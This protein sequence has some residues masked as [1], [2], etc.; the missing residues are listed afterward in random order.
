MLVREKYKYE[1][2]AKLESEDWAKYFSLS[3]IGEEYEVLYN[4]EDGM[5]IMS[6]TEYEAITN[7]EFFETIKKGDKVLSVGYGIGYINDRVIEEGA[8]LTVIE[9]YPDIVL[10]D[11]NVNP[12]ITIL[13]GDINNF[14][15]EQVFGKERFDIVYFDS[16]EYAHHGVIDRLKKLLKPKGKYIQWKHL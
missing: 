16:Y 15:F 4:T 11:E 6:D 7:Q 1:G 3:T 14:P 5:L 10:L 12:N 13:Y 2:Q 9:K 8:D